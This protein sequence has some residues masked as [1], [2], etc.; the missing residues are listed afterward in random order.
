MFQTRRLCS[1][2]L[3]TLFHLCS[4][5]DYLCDLGRT[6]LTLF[7]QL[8]NG[9]DTSTPSQSC[10]RDAGQEVGRVEINRVD[11]AKSEHQLCCPTVGKQ[12]SHSRLARRTTGNDD[13]Y[14]IGTL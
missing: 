10:V 8:Q 11:H 2:N 1:G 4:A 7:N 3:R 5:S 9:R 13:T 14:F 12:L 6:P